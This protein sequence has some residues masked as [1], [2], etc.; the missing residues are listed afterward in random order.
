MAGVCVTYSIMILKDFG[1]RI[2]GMGVLMDYLT[3]GF[4]DIGDKSSHR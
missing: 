1:I 2:G 4:I 3:L